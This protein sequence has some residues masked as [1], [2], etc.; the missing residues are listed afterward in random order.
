MESSCWM[1]TTPSSNLMRKPGACQACRKNAGASALILSLCY[2]W[3]LITA[4]M[5][6]PALK[7]TSQTALRRWMRAKIS[8]RLSARMMVPLSKRAPGGAR[9]AALSSL[10]A[11]SRFLRFAKTSYAPFQNNFAP[12]RKRLNP[13]TG[14]NQSSSPI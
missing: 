9:M 4:C 2:R 12:P 13:R 10:I 6:I 5:N 3:A 7:T 11:T 14:R 8:A 1:M